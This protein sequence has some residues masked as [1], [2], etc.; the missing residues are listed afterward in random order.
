MKK[1]YIEPFV[2]AIELEMPLLISL[3]GDNAKSMFGNGTGEQPVEGTPTVNGR[4]FDF[5]DEE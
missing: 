1:T 2:K 4:G 3:S 5:D